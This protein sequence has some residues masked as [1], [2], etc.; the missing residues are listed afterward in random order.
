[1]RLAWGAKVSSAF[2]A[3]VLSIA[4]T[5]GCD[6]SDL[7]ACMCFESAGT[8]SAAVRNPYSNAVGLIQFLPSTAIGMGTTVDDLGRLTPEEQ[9]RYVL[10]YLRPYAGRIGTLSDLYMA[11]LRPTAIGKAEDFALITSA[12]EKTYAMN[13]GLDLNQDGNITKAEAA[14]QVRD[15]L[16]RGLQVGNVWSDD[17]PATGE[18][19]MPD[20]VDTAAAITSIFNPAIG[21]AI[22][23]AG[24][25][26]K[27]FSPLLQQKAADAINKHTDNPAV[28]VQI[29]SD[30]ATMLLS[31]A[32]VLTGQPDDFKAVAAIT[33]DPSQSANLAKLQASLDAHLDKLMQAGDKAST[34]DQ[35]LWAAQNAGKQVVSSIAIEEHR[36]GLWDMTKTLVYDAAFSNTS[37]GVLL[38]ISIVYQSIWAEKGIDPVLLALAGPILMQIVSKIRD[39]L[40]YRFDGTK[41][42]SDQSK[43]LLKAAEGA[44]Q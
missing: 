21:G 25:L 39:I 31:Q 12:E 14:A 4:S 13:K 35:A 44:P 34:W 2:R 7:M 10:M 5:L 30:L 22:G 20:A 33:A 3:S 23:L 37:I 9:L 16:T 18:K 29:A 15:R 40:S 24:Q 26:F 32:K 8:F 1:M 11:I 19:P 28:G 6:P 41:Q 38:T 36:A 42:Q 27:S 43:Q 17:A